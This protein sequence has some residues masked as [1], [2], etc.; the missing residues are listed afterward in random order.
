MS[1]AHTSKIGTNDLIMDEWTVGV[2]FI[3]VGNWIAYNTAASCYPDRFMGRRR[4]RQT[5][6]AI[7]VICGSKLYKKLTPRRSH[8]STVIL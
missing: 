1:R 7:T 3:A 5:M 8:F 6:L 2:F 4:L